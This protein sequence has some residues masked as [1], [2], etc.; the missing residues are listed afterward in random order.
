MIKL[1]QMPPKRGRDSQ[2]NVQPLPVE[3]KRSA[4]TDFLSLRLRTILAYMQQERMQQ[5]CMPHF[6]RFS[7]KDH[8]TKSIDPEDD[9]YY[10][11]SLN[12]R[13]DTLISVFGFTPLHKVVH[14]VCRSFTTPTKIDEVVQPSIYSRPIVPQPVYSHPICPLPFLSTTVPEKASPGAF[15]VLDRFARN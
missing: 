7:K 10:N 2:S 8:C 5:T 11:P 14:P 1:Y 3:P 6:T 15:D 13:I 4:S 9:M 12:S